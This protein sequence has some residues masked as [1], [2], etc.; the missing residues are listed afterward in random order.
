M[1]MIEYLYAALLIIGFVLLYF[2]N[3]QYTISRNLI[4]NGVKTKAKVIDL[5]EISSDDGYTY[6]P[7]FEYL[8]RL[9]ETVTFES[10]VSSSPPAY[11]IGDYATIVYSKQNNEERKIVSFWGLY[12]WPI[13]LLCFASPLLIISLSYF[14]YLYR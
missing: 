6:K 13:I 4:N 5:L 12:R 3:K 11:R 10:A 7:V 14:G 9:D 1:K 8:N 2:A